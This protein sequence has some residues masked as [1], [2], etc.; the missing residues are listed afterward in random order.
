M[1]KKILS[2]VLGL[3]LIVPG[4]LQ[5]ANPYENLHPGNSLFTLDFKLAGKLKATLAPLLE[6]LN[7][8]ITEDDPNAG[9]A[10]VILNKIIAG[11]QLAA[12]FLLPQNIL[13]SFPTTD[14]EWETFV[15]GM[16][17]EDY[18]TDPVFETYFDDLNNFTAKLGDFGVLV[19]GGVELLHKAIDLHAGTS[20]ES[21][22]N[23][24]PYQ[25]MVSSYFSPR[26]LGFTINFSDLEEILTPMI[27]PPGELIGFFD[28]LGGSFAETETGYKFNLKV[29]AN[30]EKF[31]EADLSLNPGGNFTPN[32]H[33]KFPSAK[34]IMY[35]S[36]F[37]QAAGLENSKKFSALIEEKLGVADMPDLLE[38]FKED[39]GIDLEEVVKAFPKEFA[40]A[41]QFDENSA[42][43]YITFLGDVSANM[44]EGKAVAKGL[45][46]S[47]AQAFKDDHVSS[48]AYKIVPEG[49]FTKI[50]F[51]ITKLEDNY[52]GPPFPKIIVTIGVTE[53][54]LFIGSNYPDI[55]DPEKRTGIELP[56]PMENVTGVGYL[57]ARN[58]WKFVDAFTAWGELAG[59]GE[60]GPPLDFYNGYY[61]FLEGIYGWKDLFLYS[62]GT[63]AEATTTF[64]LNIDAAKH[65][66]YD[67]FIEEM[68]SSDQD[69]DEVSDYDE[70][71]IYM[72]PVAESDTDKDGVSDWVE[73]QSGSNPNGEGALFTDVEAN[74]YY[75]EAMG[76]LVQRG[77][78]KGYDDG[79]FG[80]GRNVNRAEFTLMI[81]KCFE[82]N[83]T[84]R[85]IG[86]SFADE[87]ENPGFTDVK[88]GAWYYEAVARAKAEG[89]VSGSVIEG[90]S[91]FRPGA[92]INRAEAIT[93]IINASKALTKSAKVAVEC[94]E[95]GYKETDWY[96]K[97]MCNSFENGISNGKDPSRPLTRAEAVVMIA[98]ALKKDITLLESGTAGIGELAAPIGAS[99]TPTAQQFLPLLELR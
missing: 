12:S 82:A 31:Q 67:Q 8:G 98:A 90:K 65:K 42:F 99:L 69:G 60:H 2:A 64:E 80:P 29:M 16:A 3:L 62:E 63:A 13:L 94:E 68:Q 1:K 83:D 47:F 66:T 34:V 51:D 21:L 54:G 10:K 52:Y 81:V 97:S 43:P 77:C 19:S 30:A 61:S 96:R 75:T 89:L 48:K 24:A 88:P 74:K 45:V 95:L 85:T 33:T 25:S 44:E 35:G 72:T 27:G 93:I 14:S 57:N 46:D 87:P 41:L 9:Q 23:K 76:L 37:N 18:G 91:V 39:S 7:N 56:R 17:R 92:E 55:E 59:G 84:N 50:T 20:T 4:V 28:Y 38:Q 36:A 49:N 71:Y 32:L 73:L 86:I 70:R 40:Y 79:T 15:E 26:L 6:E 22:A 5:A 11:D 78:I 53:D 58:T